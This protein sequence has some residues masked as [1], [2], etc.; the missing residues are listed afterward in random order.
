MC[1]AASK[2]AEVKWHGFAIDG[3]G[4]YAM[5]NVSPLPCAQPTNLAYVLV[6]DPRA[7]EQVLEEGLKLLVC[8]D[9]NWQVRRLSETDYSVVFP[10]PD[11]LKLCK[12]AADLALPGS[13]IRIIVLDSIN[14]PLGAPPPLSE[15][16]ANVLGVPPCLLEPERLKAAL[17]MVGKPLA[18]DASSLSKEPKEVLMQ[19]QIHTPELPKLVVPLYVNG[20]GSRVEIIPVKRSAAQDAAL[21]PTPSKPDQDSD[22]DDEE[23]PDENDQNDSDAH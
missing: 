13:R 12:N 8:E 20:K 17:G 23:D 4:F 14:N 16:W 7:S 11:S 18:V 15:V 1:P 19:F 6:D 10:T 22:K 5:D 3:K 21:P 2:Q 9:W